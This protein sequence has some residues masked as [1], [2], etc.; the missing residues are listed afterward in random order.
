MSYCRWSSDNFQCDLYCY[1]SDGGYVTSVACNRVL[2]P[3]PEVNFG[4]IQNGTWVMA[5]YEKRQALSDLA[6]DPMLNPSINIGLSRDGESFLDGE[7]ESFLARLESLKE[8]GY[9]FPDYVI[10]NVQEELAEEQAL[11]KSKIQKNETYEENP[12]KIRSRRPKSL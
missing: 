4:S 1:E 6:H 10:K 12:Q 11:E 3:I 9:R 7:L 8:E 5:D 2:L